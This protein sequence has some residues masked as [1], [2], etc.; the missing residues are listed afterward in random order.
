MGVPRAFAF[1]LFE[2]RASIP[3]FMSWIHEVEVLFLPLDSCCHTS[4]P[5]G[6]TYADQEIRF[7]IHSP[8]GITLPNNTGCFGFLKFHA[9][10]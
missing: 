6:H 8:S 4:I 10:P 1:Q 7:C 5:V 3:Q 9:L 2:D